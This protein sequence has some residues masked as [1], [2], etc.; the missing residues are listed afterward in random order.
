MGVC[1]CEAWCVGRGLLVA[2]GG[3]DENVERVGSVEV[4]QRALLLLLLV[5][6]CLLLLVLLLLWGLSAGDGAPLLSGGR[7]QASAVDG[8]VR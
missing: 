7:D 8:G 6:L 5:L 3:R 2:P 4:L 1:G